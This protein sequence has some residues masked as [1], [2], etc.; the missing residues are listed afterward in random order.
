MGKIVDNL[1]ELALL[2]VFLA[3]LLVGQASPTARLDALGG[4]RTEHSGK[5]WQSPHF[6]QLNSALRCGYAFPQLHDA[7]LADVWRVLDAVGESE[8]SVRLRDVVR[9]C[10]LPRACLKAATERGLEK[11]M[12]Q[13]KLSH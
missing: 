12:P 4:C 8:T 9:A 1:L 6:D 11:D 5:V 7:K 13:R 10:A 2:A 3:A